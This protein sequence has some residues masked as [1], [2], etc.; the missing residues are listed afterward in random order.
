MFI[1]EI[2]VKTE[3]GS[4]IPIKFFFNNPLIEESPATQ[5]DDLFNP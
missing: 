5:K 1:H 4:P 2:L 3:K